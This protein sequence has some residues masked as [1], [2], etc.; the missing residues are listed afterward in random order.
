LGAFFLYAAWKVLGIWYTNEKFYYYLIFVALCVAGFLIGDAAFFYK[1]IKSLPR[2]RLFIFLPILALCLPWGEWLGFGT[3]FTRESWS[4]MLFLQ[5][6]F[7]YG[8]ILVIRAFPEFAALTRSAFTRFIN[9]AASRTVLVWFPAVLLFLLTAAIAFFVN[10]E[11]PVVQDSAAHLFQAKIF[12]KFKLFAPQPAVPEAF[13]GSLDLLV[14][15]KGKWYGMYFPGFAALMAP[16]SWLQLEW[17]V[18]PLLASLSCMLWI[19]YARRWHNDKTAVLFGCLM[20]LSPFVIVMSSTVMVFTPE[21]FFASATIVFARLTL[22]K[23]TVT[24][25]LALSFVLVGG[26]LVRFF[27]LIPLLLPILIYSSWQGLRKNLI[28]IPIA[29]TAGILIGVSLVCW[30]QYET[31]GN[32]LIP[33]YKIEVSDLGIGFGEHEMGTHSPLRAIDNVSNNL[34]GLNYY[35]GGWLSGSLLFLFAFLLRQ[36]IELWDKL[37]LAGCACVMAFYFTRFGQDLFFGPRNYYSFTPILLLFIAR[38]FTEESTESKFQ[39]KILL[40]LLVITILIS[41]PMNLPAFVKRYDPGRT[42]AGQLKEQIR[43]T[44]GKPTLVFLDKNV[45]QNFVNWNDPFLKSSI[46]ICR[47]FGERN[48]EVEKLFPNYRPVWFRM[49]MSF[50]KGQ[51]NNGFM[52]T[53]TPDR[54]PEGTLSLFELGMALQAARQ[55]PKRDFF[56]V[57]YIDLFNAPIAVK[58]YK[59][60]DDAEKEKPS[61]VKYKREFRR[62]IL[63][64]GKMLLLPKIAFEQHGNSWYTV[65][66]PEEFRKEF[67]QAQ[68]AFMNSGEIGKSILAEMD[69]VQSRID[70][71]SDRNLSDSEILLFLT[72]KIKLLSRGGSL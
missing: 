18:S 11:T 13:T 4:E 39:P 37:L 27:S 72:E 62:G 45:S 40:P 21:L 50:E 22:E 44:D 71:N 33:G 19:F 58:Y 65:F 28:K 7:I 20:L 53:D 63:H 3:I 69:K 38:N 61:R 51:V 54:T 46:I 8:F 26:F 60:L 55:L 6:I 29:I 30:Y 34:L 43:K 57:C 32:P 47:D 15:E 14:M 16:A 23:P 64:A 66:N 2:R 24:N 68:D 36:K 5:S 70:Q 25:I 52:F 56:D 31:T 9:S 59:F 41:V 49:N 1:Q 35:L 67:F 48:K 12:S 42:Q 10:R 17:I